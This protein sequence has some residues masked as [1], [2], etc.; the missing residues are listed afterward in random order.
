MAAIW[1]V[2]ILACSGISTL[3]FILRKLNKYSFIWCSWKWIFNCFKVSFETRKPETPWSAYILTYVLLS[4]AMRTLIHFLR[5]SGHFHI[6]LIRFYI[7]NFRLLQDDTLV[8]FHS[9]NIV[10][11]NWRFWF[12]F[13]GEFRNWCVPT[14]IKSHHMLNCGAYFRPEKYVAWLFTN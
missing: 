2:S 10:H 12:P 11:F 13:W 7:T 6:K 4:L 14:K 9:L 3:V 1:D 5:P 8:S